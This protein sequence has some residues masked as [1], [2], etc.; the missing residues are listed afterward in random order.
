MKINYFGDSLRMS[1]RGFITFNRRCFTYHII[2]MF[3][4]CLTDPP[5]FL[6]LPSNLTQILSSDVYM[7]ETERGAIGRIVIT[8]FKS[9]FHAAV[10]M[11]AFAG[12]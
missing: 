3:V 4:I 6:P 1:I 11:F 5:T 7:S 2:T 9:F 8:I 12:K 10:V